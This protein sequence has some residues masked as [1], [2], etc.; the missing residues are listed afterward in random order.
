MKTCKFCGIIIDN[1]EHKYAK[2]FCSPA[3]GSKWNAVQMAKE[4]NEEWV[5]F[6]TLFCQYCGKK[7]KVR[8]VHRNQKYC[9]VICYYKAKKGIPNYKNRGRGVKR[10]ECWIIS[11]CAECG[12][13]FE[14]RMSGY[15]RKFCS[16]KCSAKN[17]I[18]KKGSPRPDLSERNKK[19]WKEDRNGMM[20]I[21]KKSLAIRKEKGEN[22]EEY[23]QK[24]RE[25]G[26][27]CAHKYLV[28]YFKTH[29]DEIIKKAYKSRKISPNE[30]EKYLLKIL[31]D[32]D[33]NWM[34]VGD[35][36]FI[37]GHKMPDY[38]YNGKNLLIEYFGDYWHSSKI[39]GIP[40]QEHETERIQHFVKYGYKCLVIWY[41][42]LKNIDKLKEKIR[43]F[44]ND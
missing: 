43:K 42:E 15:K 1:K 8:W 38:L 35:G 22:D 9:S 41:N 16:R 40:K 23:K 6:I 26:S 33:I 32:V 27:R 20:A 30:K 3:C 19:R 12:K 14:Y 17:S 25:N 24:Q 31:N 34:F 39:T 4:K 5:E 13:E 28:P 44:Q 18:G 37:V 29:K 11:K 7:F 10:P 36:S 2:D 21:V